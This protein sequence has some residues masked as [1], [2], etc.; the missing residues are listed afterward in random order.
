M[1]AAAVCP[2]AAERVWTIVGWGSGFDATARAHS[3]RS[4]ASV[5]AFV[6]GCLYQ[7]VWNVL[8]GRDRGTG[9][10]DYDLIY[11]DD[12]DLIGRPRIW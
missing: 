10:E 5:A 12:G 11:F 4:S 7:T 6:A 2:G 3:T 1:P 9:I 8:T